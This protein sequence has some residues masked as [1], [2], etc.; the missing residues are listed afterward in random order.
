MLR[1]AILWRKKPEAQS[2]EKYG[3]TFPIDRTDMYNDSGCVVLDGTK[4]GGPV[5]DV[6]GRGFPHRQGMSAGLAGKGGA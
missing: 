2:T 4:L 5:R 1:W 6:G 3:I